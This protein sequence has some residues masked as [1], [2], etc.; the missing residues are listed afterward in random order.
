MKTSSHGMFGAVNVDMIWSTTR[1]SAISADIVDIDDVWI[2]PVVLNVRRRY[3]FG[4]MVR[5]RSSK[6]SSWHVRISDRQSCFGG[7]VRAACMVGCWTLSPR[8]MPMSHMV[9]CRSGRLGASV[10]RM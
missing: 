3:L 9:K 6:N 2:V 7:G 8:L 5:V 4:G 1:P 10:A